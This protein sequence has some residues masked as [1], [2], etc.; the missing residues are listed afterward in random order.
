V[1]LAEHSAR[2]PLLTLALAGAVTLLALA[3]I[4]RLRLETSLGAMLGPD[5]PVVRATEIIGARFAA[6]HE[7]LIVLWPDDETSAAA[8]AATAE[9]IAAHLGDLDPEWGNPEWG[10]PEWGGIASRRRGP[11]SV[12]GEP[13]TLIAGIR[14]TSE[15]AAAGA[16]TS[17]KSSPP[18]HSTTPTMPPSRRPSAASPPPP[19]APASNA[20]K[21]SSPPPEALPPLPPKRPL[22][23]RSA[24]AN[25]SPAAARWLRWRATRGNH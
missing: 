22:A 24:S 12:E 5:R 3:G 21:P 16:P 6:G 23:I 20:S 7:L 2:R 14:I 4:S 17:P 13:P 18:P 8:R 1:R 19:C 9:R 25:S 10:N 15:D 11:A